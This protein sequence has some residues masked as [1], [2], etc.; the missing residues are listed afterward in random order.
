M[1]PTPLARAAFAEKAL[2]NAIGIGASQYL[3]LASGYDTFAYR[4]PI[5]SKHIQIFEVYHTLTASHKQKRLKNAGIEIPHNVNY[6]NADFTDEGLEKALINNKVFNNNKISFT[7]I[8]GL[9]YY[10]TKQELSCLLNSLSLILAKGSSIVFEYPDENTHTEKAGE[11]T[12]KQSMMASA[13][14]EKWFLDIHI[15]T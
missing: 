15:K 9:L 14:N 12:K 6:I 4:Q 1:S 2:E 13:V 11:R 5:W 10:N 8:L 3:I 7:S